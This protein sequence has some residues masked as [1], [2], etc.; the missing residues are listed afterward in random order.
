MARDRGRKGAQPHA[1]WVLGRIPVLECLRARRRKPKQLYVLRSGKGLDEVVAAA[2][3]LPVHEATR[4]E[5]DRLTGGLNHQGVALEAGPLPV[6]PLNEWLDRGTGPN[7]TVL[8]LDEVQDPHNFGAMVRSAAA[9]G[10]TAVLFGKDRS[11]PLSPTAAKSAAGA[12]E[13]VDLL[14]ATNLSRAL[15]L[16]KKAG[17]WVA[18]L[19]AEADQ[20]LWDADLSGKTAL[21]IGS[22][23]KGLRRL[24]REHCDVLI[25]IPLT[26]PIT[27]LN[28]S[29]SAGIAL[30][31]CVRQRRG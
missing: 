22:E 25:S 24:V 15:E 31:E 30:A 2:G 28:A 3:H 9:C 17:F 14:Q 27:S 12:M 10:A 18:G 21:V 7:T 20:C 16:L 23:G 5:L 13:Y 4:E 26:G 6:F 29:V 11:A 19:A 8:V 1:D